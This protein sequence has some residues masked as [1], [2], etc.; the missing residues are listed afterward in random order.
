MGWQ[1]RGRNR[2][3]NGAPE[4]KRPWYGP[5]DLRSKSLGKN[6]KTPE[7][8]QR[9]HSYESWTRLVRTARRGPFRLQA[10]GRTAGQQ[11]SL[12]ETFC[13]KKPWGRPPSPSGRYEQLAGKMV[14]R[15]TIW[16]IVSEVLSS[17]S[18]TRNSLPNPS[19][20]VFSHGRPILVA[21]FHLPVS[22]FSIQKV[23][24]EVNLRSPETHT[25][26]GGTVNLA[27]GVVAGNVAS[28]Y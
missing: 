3:I 5:P 13:S 9:P 7:T 16:S 8:G 27:V 26:F 2:R 24:E 12:S 4:P 6:G 15:G 11:H 21:S 1:R 22:F 28:G 10:N 17:L 14:K 18:T 19:L 20:P 25:Y 23:F